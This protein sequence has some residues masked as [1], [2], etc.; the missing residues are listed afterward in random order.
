M[1]KVKQVR[2]ALCLES[3]MTVSKSLSPSANFSL[4]HP[5]R[6]APVGQ[7]GDKEK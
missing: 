1:G 5:N 7:A 6:P 3:L 4:F 2:P